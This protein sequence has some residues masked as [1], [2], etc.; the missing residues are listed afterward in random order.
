MS[1]TEKDLSKSQS[2]A[3]DDPE[4]AEYN[5][6]DASGGD[7]IANEAVVD[8]KDMYRMG[9]N[10]QFRVRFFEPELVESVG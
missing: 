10:Q 7:I 3:H 5:G 2:D 9:K 6:N 1:T 8:S 4:L